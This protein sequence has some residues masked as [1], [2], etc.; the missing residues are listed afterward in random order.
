M[1]VLLFFNKNLEN[2]MN[3]YDC[4][5][6]LMQSNENHTCSQGFLNIFIG[7]Q[8]KLY[9]ITRFSMFVWFWT[10]WI[11]SAF[12]YRLPSHSLQIT[13]LSLWITRPPSPI[14]C[15][16]IP[17]RLPTFPYRSSQKC[18]ESQKPP[19]YYMHLYL[20]PCT[21]YIYTLFT[22]LLQQQFLF[23]G[24]YDNRIYHNGHITSL[25]HPSEG[26]YIYIYI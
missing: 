8:Q 24:H 20:Y 4:C 1:Y 11:G 23:G 17:Y 10:V 15:Q 12:P 16:G 9:I 7:K 22:Y 5:F 26:L 13:N 25:K 14:D 21:T 18:A 3:M 2:F 19:L 6:F